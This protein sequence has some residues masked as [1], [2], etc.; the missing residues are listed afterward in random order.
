MFSTPEV[1]ACSPMCC[2]ALSSPDFEYY[3]PSQMLLL[4]CQDQ[5]EDLF[6]FVFFSKFLRCIFA[7]IPGRIR[8]WWLSTIDCLQQLRQLPPWIRK[9]TQQATNWLPF[10]K[11]LACLALSTSQSGDKH[12]VCVGSHLSPLLSHQYETIADEFLKKRRR[13]KKKS[14]AKHL[15][16]LFDWRQSQSLLL[17]NP[18][19]NN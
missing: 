11:P 6:F 19:G 5:R 1:A 16:T 12:L 2:L 18:V 13:G 9:K 8:W 3:D 17:A 4:I 7:H 10:L 14:S 15:C